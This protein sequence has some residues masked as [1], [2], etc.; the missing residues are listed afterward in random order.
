MSLLECDIDLGW[1]EFCSPASASAA[2][3]RGGP[4]NLWRMFDSR[5]ST[6]GS[7]PR[8]A[9]PLEAPQSPSAATPPFADEI[10]NP[11]HPLPDAGFTRPGRT[12]PTS[13]VVEDKEPAHLVQIPLLD[14]STEAAC[15]PG[16]CLRCTSTT[17]TPPDCRGPSFARQNLSTRMAASLISLL[18][19]PLSLQGINALPSKKRALVP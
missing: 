3:N 9:C 6:A 18:K 8:S 10:A 11:R 4:Q 15:H 1:T 17:S 7:A 13:L 14:R 2:T 5:P 12:S 19:A 16:P